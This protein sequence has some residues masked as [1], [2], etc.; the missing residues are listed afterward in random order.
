MANRLCVAK[1]QTNVVALCSPRHKAKTGRSDAYLWG[2]NSRET[3]LKAFERLLDIMD[4]LREKCPWDRKQTFESLRHLTIEE[5]YELADAILDGDMEE[6][7]KETGDLLLHMV[8]YA[9]LGSERPAS[10][11][12]F[13]IADSLN[14]ICDKLVERHPHI[15]GDVEANDEETVKA[16]W[17]KLKLK[18]GKKSVL[19][20]VPK[21]LPSL[22]KAYRVQ[23]KVRGVG[24]DWDEVSQVWDKVQEELGEL[25][26]ELDAQAVDKTRVADE[27]G[28]VLFALINY[29]RFVDVNPDEAL[30]RT[31]RRFMERFQHLETAVALEGKDLA[32]MDLKEMDVYWER[33]KA[34]FNR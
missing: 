26:E 21:S 20:G 10:E 24:F 15:Y 9:K 27:F 29:A 30:E 3:Q 31:T 25:R 17:E 5:T 13:D 16:N 23:D 6:V 1:V 7:K 8:F 2:M 22:V 34:H 19:E 14:A 4:D 28:D 11:G 32:A 18:E 33:A 12:G